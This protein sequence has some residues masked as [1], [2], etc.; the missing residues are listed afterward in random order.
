M[1]IL[2]G[3]DEAAEKSFKVGGNRLMTLHQTFLHQGNALL[4]KNKNLD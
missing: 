2:D 3:I 4:N 1:S